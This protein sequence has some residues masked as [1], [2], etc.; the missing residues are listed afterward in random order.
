MLQ[1]RNKQVLP[2]HKILKQDHIYE[3]YDIS[4]NSSFYFT[5]GF[6]L[7]LPIYPIHL[8]LTFLSQG[9]RNL[10]TSVKNSM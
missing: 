10:G 2:F 4:L 6:L 5:Y 7:R 1:F 9:L 3:I 8:Y